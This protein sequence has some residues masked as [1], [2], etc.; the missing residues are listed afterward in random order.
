MKELDK[1]INE[2]FVGRVVRKDLTSLVKG[3]M[4][5]PTYVLEYLL[6]QYCATS[7][8]ETIKS[9]VE[10]V[11]GIITKHF[12]HRDEANEVKFHIKD[13]GSYRIIDKVAVRLNERKECVPGCS[14][15][16]ESLCDQRFFKCDQGSK[17]LGEVRSAVD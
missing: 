1:K 6:G 7:D 3:N 15:I 8:E 14:V 12:V 4:S 5:I 13:K 9:G 17:R 10:T 11:R 16:F 2:T